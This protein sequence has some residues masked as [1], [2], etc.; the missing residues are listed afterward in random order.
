MESLLG[1]A[2]AGFYDTEK[3]DLVVRG[4]QEEATELREQLA[5]FV[6]AVLLAEEQVLVKDLA[7]RLQVQFHDSAPQ[8]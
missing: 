5:E 7:R 8:K 1:A 4:D 6:P 2:V 3:D